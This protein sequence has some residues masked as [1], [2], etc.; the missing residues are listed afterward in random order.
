VARGL[1][2]GVHPVTGGA[3]G[4]AELNFMLAQCLP[5]GLGVVSE[6]ATDLGAARPPLLVQVYGQACM[7]SAAFMLVRGL[8]G[9]P[10]RLRIASTVVGWTAKRIARSLRRSPAR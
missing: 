10:S 3:G 1:G 9:M 7:I 6:V 2:S 5:G 8:D 4:V